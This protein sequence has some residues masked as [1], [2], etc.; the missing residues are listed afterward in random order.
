MNKTSTLF[1]RCVV[2]VLGLAALAFCVFAIPS[3][4]AEAGP[5]KPIL[6]GM[7]VSIIPFFYALYQTLKLLGVIDANTA[8]SDVSVK[9]LKH[10]RYS[11]IV[12][13]L[14]YVLGM[15]Y[16]Y[17]AADLDD[18]PGVIVIGLVIILASIVIAVFAVVLQ[19]LLS[20]A[21]DIKQENDLM[22]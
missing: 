8:F 17:H 20:Q 6:I 1:L 10:I 18:A 14:M 9:G 15:P 4:W 2:Y 5:Y 13:S 19:K 16:I 21:L 3:V 12:I 22:V 7:C 11:A